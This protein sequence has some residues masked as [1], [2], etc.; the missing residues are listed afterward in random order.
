MTVG[1]VERDPATAEFFDGTAS[2]QFRL[3][4]CPD[5]HYSEP[6]ASQ[7]TTCGRTDLEWIAASGGASL[8]SWAVTWTRGEADS[9]PAPTV[10]VIGELD[11]GPWWWSQ[12]VGVS[13]DAVAVGQRLRTEFQRSGP[14]YEAVPVFRLA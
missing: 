9:E 14:E 3:R 12:L 8:V 1:P 6:A 10:L 4:R 11:E 5:Q 13:P 2:G 7:C